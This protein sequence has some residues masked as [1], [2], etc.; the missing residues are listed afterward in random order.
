[1]PV[2][3]L[4]DVSKYIHL[5]SVH[6]VNT[7]VLGKGIRLLMYTQCS[8]NINTSGD[9]NVLFAKR[10]NSMR[11]INAQLMTAYDVYYPEGGTD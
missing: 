4:K 8:R 5:N 11:W 2:D 3:I 9:V 1:M 6:F 10:F 7:F